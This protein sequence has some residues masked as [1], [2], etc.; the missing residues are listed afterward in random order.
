LLIT[1]VAKSQEI[2][3]YNLYNQNLYLLSPAAIGVNGGINAFLGHKTQWTG[4]NNTPQNTYFS[5]DGLLTNSMGMG[6]ILSDQ[7][8]GIFDFFNAN[9]SYAYRIAF[10]NYQAISFGL[11]VNFVKNSINSSSLYDEELQD[12]ALMSNKFDQS[13]FYTGLAVEYRYK[14]FVANLSS[15]VIFSAQEKYLFQ[16]NF[17]YL[18]YDF[19]FSNN[20]WRLQ[21][22]ILLKYMTYSP[23]Q[24]D[25]NIL[26][27]WKRTVW[28]QISYRTNKEMVFTT[29]VMVKNISIGYSYELGFKPIS[30]IS[31]GSHEIVVFFNLPKNF[32]KEKPTYFK[33]LNSNSWD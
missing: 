33:S 4:M 17:L 24:A 9:I 18:G 3:N 26:G 14:N 6:M 2:P 13:L 7:K 32:S 28:A 21:P 10:S 11:N 22:S 29:G 25:I 30:Y 5:I 19:Y 31:D 27:D 23:F 15:P 1:F 20:I 16:T 8:M 12:P